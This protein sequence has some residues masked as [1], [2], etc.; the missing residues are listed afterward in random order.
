VQ[1]ARIEVVY[2]DGSC[3]KVRNDVLDILI[4]TERIARFRRRDGW[5]DILA[6]AAILRDFRGFQSYRGGERRA[7]W[8][9]RQEPLP[10]S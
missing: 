9:G 4:A 5:V 1:A 6:D 10:G 8:P 7:P 3:G 2:P